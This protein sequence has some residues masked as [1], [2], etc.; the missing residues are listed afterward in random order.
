MHDTARMKR[1]IAMLALLCAAPLAAAPGDIVTTGSPAG[2]G[3]G[4]KPP[5]FMKPGDVIEIEIEG[6]G[7]MEVHVTDPLKRR[8]DRGVYMGENSTN[9]AAVAAAKAAAEAKS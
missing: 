2:V 3:V 8:W 4:R 9:R 1:P 6:I 5:V 7:A